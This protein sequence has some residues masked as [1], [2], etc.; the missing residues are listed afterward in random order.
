MQKFRQHLT[1]APTI[2]ALADATR[3]LNLNFRRVKLRFR[4][5]PRLMEAQTRLA[6][7]GVID[8][9]RQTAE[10]SCVEGGC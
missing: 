7:G 5:R 6:R 4:L 2:P 10:G 8:D 1:D 9:E 3:I